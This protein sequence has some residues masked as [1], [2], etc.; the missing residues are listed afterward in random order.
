V[1]TGSL[2]ALGSDAPW[3]VGTGT[4]DACSDDTDAVDPDADDP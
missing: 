3:E 1:A 2:V 4:D